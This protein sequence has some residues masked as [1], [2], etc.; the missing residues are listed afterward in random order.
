MIDQDVLKWQKMINELYMEEN[1]GDKIHSAIADIAGELGIT[2]IQLS[3]QKDRDADTERTL[4][5]DQTHSKS[6]CVETF[7]YSYGK[8]EDVY[9]FRIYAPSEEIFNR[10][11]LQFL[12]FLTQMVFVV[13][14]SADAR[15]HRKESDMRD[16]KTGIGNLNY[17]FHKGQAL[18][19][20]G[21][22]EE[23]AAV[24]FNIKNFKH[25]PPAISQ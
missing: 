17:L 21:R 25:Y 18:V 10:K 13:M 5:L 1:P 12:E 14:S 7:Q 19:E 11:T 23:F 8:G 15:K 16:W 24:Y 4:Y 2:M 22:I 6:D 20:Q 3:V 9:Q